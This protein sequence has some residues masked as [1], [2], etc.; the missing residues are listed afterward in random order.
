ML[1]L[2]I[3]VCTKNS[4]KSIIK[5]LKSCLPLLKV[6]A[7]IIIVDGCSNDNTV[8]LILE[9]LK[10][11][12]VV[13]YKIVKQIK[14]GLYDAFNIAIENASRKRLFFLHSDDVIQLCNILIKDVR[15]CASDIIF[16]GVEIKGKY[17]RRIWHLKNIRDINLGIMKIPP[18]VGILINKAVYSKIGGF[19]TEY[20]IAGDFDWMLR[21]L[22]SKKSSF[23]FSKHVIYI[24]EAGG[25][26]NAGFFSEIKKF[27][28]DVKV[29]KHH[30]FTFPICRVFLKKLNKLWQ[31][32]KL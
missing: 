1:D 26:S 25:V 11:N 8:N 31:F 21:L 15:K 16:Y 5:C 19:N 29:L 9:F 18:H 3:L 20:K 32:E 30:R 6:N 22:N 17:S 7:E 2:S 10:F 4:D 14:S 13:Y 28:E 27:Y 12:K 24:M 23:S